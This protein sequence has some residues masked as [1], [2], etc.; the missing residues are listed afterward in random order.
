MR[1]RSQAEHQIVS[2]PKR[3]LQSH[4]LHIR[5]RP[6]HLHHQL[7]STVDNHLTRIAWFVPEC[8]APE[9]ARDLV[10]TPSYRTNTHRE[11]PNAKVPFQ[12]L[13]GTASEGT[14]TAP[15]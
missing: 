5:F 6:H 8:A 4:V 7:P 9:R 2:R 13:A 11:E 10:R 12:R 1:D 14:R 15:P 3:E